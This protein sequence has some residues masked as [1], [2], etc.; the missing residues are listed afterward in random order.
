MLRGLSPL[1]HREFRLLAVGQLASNIGDAFYAV[2][3][4]WYVLADHGGP[5]LLGTV[6]A[7]YGIPRV[8]LVAVGGHASDRWGPWTVMMTADFVRTVAVAGLAGVATSGPAQAVFLIPIATVLG[9]GEGLFLPGSFAIV[10]SLL[11]DDDLQAGN[12]L[13]SGGT[14]LAALIGPAIGGAVVAGFGSDTAFAVDAATFALSAA[15][16]AQIRTQR[17]PSELDVESASSI[18]APELARGPSDPDATPRLTL[19]GLVATERVL[20]LILLATFAANLGFGGMSEVALPALARGPFHAGA[21]GYGGLIAAFGAGALLGTL[22]AAQAPNARRPAVLGSIAYLVEAGACA[23]VPYIGGAIPAG[24]ALIVFGALEGFGNIII[25]T[26]FQRWTPPEFRGRV[27]GLLMLAAV[28]TFPVSVLLAGLVVHS[29]GA[30]AFFPLNAAVLGATIL[31][32]LTQR[33]WRDFGTPDASTAP[34]ASP[35]RVSQ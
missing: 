7:A 19:R 11:P 8:V 10:P 1:R 2:A 32:A 13:S 15:T 12:A 18:T 5:L 30:A 33:S 31:W 21:G 22:I 9:A 6:L 24:V 3:L 20:Q 16:L 23:V 28:G 34:T 29:L 14:Q 25:I 27:M 4:P 17:S 26:A 35:S